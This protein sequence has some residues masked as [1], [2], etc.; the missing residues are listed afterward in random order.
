MKSSRMPL[1]ILWRLSYQALYNI[2]PRLLQNGTI[3]SILEERKTN[4]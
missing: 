4:S 2:A 3:S 1:M